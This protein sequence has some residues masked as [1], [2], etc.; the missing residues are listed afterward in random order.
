MVY[1]ELNKLIITK[2]D[3]QDARNLKPNYPLKPCVILYDILYYNG[4]GLI[5]TPLEERR[6]LL[7]RVVKETVGVTYLSQLK[8]R[9]TN[10][11]VLSD[12]NSAIEHEE[13]GIV[14]KKPSSL[15]VPDGRVDSGWF[16]VNSLN[17]TDC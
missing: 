5:S 16:K 9:S 7:E 13:E 11:Q 15:Y 14:L 1:D 8:I 6:R 12:L 3:G 2:A 17:K 4:A 10:E